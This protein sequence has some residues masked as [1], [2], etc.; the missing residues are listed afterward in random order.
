L[1]SKRLHRKIARQ[2]KERNIAIK[3]LNTELSLKGTGLEG[4]HDPYHPFN[5]FE[6][7]RLTQR[8]VEICYRLFD[9]GK[10]EMA[11]A[12][13]MRLSLLAVRKRKKM[14]ATVGGKARNPV[15]IESLPQ[16]KFYRR[17]NA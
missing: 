5:H 11:V 3:K 2:I 16:R 4:D 9:L 10:S 14:W 17:R 13:L 7:K 1:E 15:D 6:N 8:G 12:H